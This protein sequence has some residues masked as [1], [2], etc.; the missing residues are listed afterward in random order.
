MRIF[1]V[2]KILKHLNNITASH[3]QFRET[4]TKWKLQVNDCLEQF[5]QKDKLFSNLQ[6]ENEKLKQIL[7]EERRAMERLLPSFSSDQAPVPRIP[8]PASPRT[9][10]RQ[11]DNSNIRFGASSDGAAQNYWIIPAIMDLGQ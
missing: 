3:P 11:G 8:L 5:D 1:W 7:S 10:H 2:S 4:V 6:L 9:P